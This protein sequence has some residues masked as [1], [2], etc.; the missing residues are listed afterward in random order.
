MADE[1]RHEIL[2]AARPDF[3][4]I[5]RNAPNFQ[6][7]V[8]G[9]RPEDRE[10]QEQINQLQ[11]R[12]DQHLQNQ[13]RDRELA[14]TIF[15]LLGLFP[16]PVV[17]YALLWR[18][19]RPDNWRTA[20][21]RIVTTTTL[22]LVRLGR[23]MAYMV[24]TGNWIKDIVRFLTVF[25]SMV[26]FS[27]NFFRDIFTYMVRNYPLL[28]Q[29]KYNLLHEQEGE[30]EWEN[31]VQFV[32]DN[33]AMYVNT[34]CVFSGDGDNGGYC[35]LHEQLLIFRFSNALIKIFPGFVQLPNFM[36]TFTT[37]CIYLSY[38]LIGQFLGFNVLFFF[39]LHIGHRWVP[40]LLFFG[41]CGKAAWQSTGTMVF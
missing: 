40:L 29:R 39:M 26:T 33:L 20:L 32:C 2:R 5:F 10:I 6:F 17:N 27:D 34:H 30:I 31:L 37:V 36:L 1:F 22:I 9:I 12:I 8:N 25:G 7:F 18:R 3:V 16:I 38:G 14:I 41:K 35:T 24:L 21:A 13:R 23:L 4:G 28:V 19:N 15:W 11:Q